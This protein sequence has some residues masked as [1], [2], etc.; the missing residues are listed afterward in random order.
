MTAERLHN[1]G[2]VFEPSL[3]Q[4]GWTSFRTRSSHFVWIPAVLPMPAFMVEPV[5]SQYLAS[6]SCCRAGSQVLEQADPRWAATKP[7]CV[8]MVL[9]SN[10]TT[11]TTTTNNNNNNNNNNNTKNITYTWRC[12]EFGIWKGEDR[13]ISTFLGPTIT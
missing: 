10:N 9:N 5:V 7:V 1:C 11:T 6:R 4:A 13:G 8:F 3:F 2:D 12:M